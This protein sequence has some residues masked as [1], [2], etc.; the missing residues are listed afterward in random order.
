MLVL[1]RLDPRPGHDHR[2][3]PAADLGHDLGDEVIDHHPHLLLDV[4][5]VELDEPSDRP[6]ALRGFDLRIVERSLLEL[7]E[8]LV[9]RV[10]LEDVEDELLLDRLPH[11]I[12]VERAALSVSALLSEQRQRLGLRSRGESEVGHMRKGPHP[13]HVIDQ[14]I[15]AVRHVVLLLVDFGHL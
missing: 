4:V 14:L 11:R 1:H 8:G 12:Q 15:L 9:R 6:P 2:L 7:E 3:G 5:R 10:V 13:A